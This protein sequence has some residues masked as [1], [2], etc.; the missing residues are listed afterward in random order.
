MYSDEQQD[1]TEKDYKCDKCKKAISIF[2]VGFLGDTKDF[3]EIQKVETHDFEGDFEC[4]P[5]MSLTCVC[6]HCYKGVARSEQ[7]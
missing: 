4:S 6:R 7:G 5:H 3:E 2:D 1:D